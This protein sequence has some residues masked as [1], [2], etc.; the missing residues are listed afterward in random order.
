MAYLATGDAH[1]AEDLLQEAFVRLGG[2]VLTLSD[3]ERAA[4]YLYRTV[5]NLSRDHGR[6]VRRDRDIHKR[7]TGDKP[8]PAPDIG[9]RDQVWSAL[10][11][12]PVRHRAVLFLRYYIDLS[13]AQTAD[14][15]GCSVSAVKSLNH[16]AS[17]TLRKQLQG[18]EA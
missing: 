1:E 8:A 7:L 5:I 18:D 10:L 14:V 16:R 12:L 11:S 3:P 15:L 4:G 9:D 13:E 6:R 2:R 17:E